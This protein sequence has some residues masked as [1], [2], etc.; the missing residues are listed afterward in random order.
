MSQSDSVTVKV[1]AHTY[2][3][4][5]LDPW[6]M[7]EITHKI[8]NTFG[9]TVG[10]LILALLAG[11][12]DDDDDFKK[13]AS[14]VADDPSA[15]LG[16]FLEKRIDS[17]H[18]ASGISQA[19]RNLDATESRW[20]M[21]QLADSTTIEGGRKL[22]DV[23]SAHFLGRPLDMYRWALGALRSQYSFLDSRLDTDR[24]GRQP[25]SQA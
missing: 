9:D 6:V 12:S 3:C 8:L 19:L 20:L 21:E 10:E 2:N 24:S 7:N 13:E 14:E 23:W 15:K 11:K 16:S 18:L 5:K 4:F 22:L 1:G 25:H 17:K